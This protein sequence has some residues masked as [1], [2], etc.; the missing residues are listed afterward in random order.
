MGFDAGLGA[1]GS[2]RDPWV[3]QGKPDKK[4]RTEA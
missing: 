1:R 4:G 3:G 2:L